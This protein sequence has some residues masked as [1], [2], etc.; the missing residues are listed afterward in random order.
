MD[1]TLPEEIESTRQQVAKFVEEV[2]L[3]LEKDASNFDEHENL[4]E[5]VVDSIREQSKAAGLW[6]FQMPKSRGGR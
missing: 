3:P 6:G 4:K 5:S 1:F 2:M